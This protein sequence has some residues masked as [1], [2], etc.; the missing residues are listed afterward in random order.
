MILFGILAIILV[1][2]AVVSIFV[3]TVGGTFG[4]IVF[5]DLIVCIAII[6]FIMRLVFKKKH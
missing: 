5:S 3:L 2:L 4:I 6:A 1:L